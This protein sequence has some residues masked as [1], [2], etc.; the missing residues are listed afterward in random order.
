MTCTINKANK[1]FAQLNFKKK[2]DNMCAKL[3]ESASTRTAQRFKVDTTF[4]HVEF[5]TIVYAN[6][7]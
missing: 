1:N 6:A 3:T 2:S 5:I 7:S 4:V